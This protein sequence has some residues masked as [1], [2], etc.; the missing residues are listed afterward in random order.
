MA[1]YT[2]SKIIGIKKGKKIGERSIKEIVDSS[3]K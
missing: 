1:S 2:I 3:F